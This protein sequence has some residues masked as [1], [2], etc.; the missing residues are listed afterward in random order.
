MTIAWRSIAMRL[1]G[2]T[3]SSKADADYEAIGPAFRI[4]AVLLILL[5]PV[6]AP[7]LADDESSETCRV[8][9][10]WAFQRP[11]ILRR[12]AVTSDSAAIQSP[13][14]ATITRDQ[15]RVTWRVA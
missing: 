10:R 7:R 13:N 1:P 2:L 4:A 14:A 15:C 9:A 11:T 3:S 6:V 8:D 12:L 5:S